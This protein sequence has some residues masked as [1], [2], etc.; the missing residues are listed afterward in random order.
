MVAK[1]VP[2]WSKIGPDAALKGD[3]DSKL[4]KEG[5]KFVEGVAPE[6]RG[7][8]AG[9]QTGGFWALWGRETGR[10]QMSPHA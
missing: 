8:C 9:A 10:G 1:S 2:K 6:L 4:K 3:S 7:S 5:A